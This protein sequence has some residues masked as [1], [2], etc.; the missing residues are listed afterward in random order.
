M[1]EKLKNRIL[2]ASIV[3][4][5]S[6]GVWLGLVYRDHNDTKEHLDQAQFELSNAIAGSADLTEKLLGSSNRVNELE[7]QQ[8]ESSA[9]T[10]RLE[11]E[12]GLGADYIFRLEGA[13]GRGAESV[14][15]L[16]SGFGEIAD[17]LR[18]GA[19]YIKDGEE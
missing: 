14:E 11:R 1:N 15:R 16:D 7:K 18:Q 17:L 2:V 4:N 6:L 13:L 10:K 5:L 12:L 3:L 9:Y 8:R 19:E